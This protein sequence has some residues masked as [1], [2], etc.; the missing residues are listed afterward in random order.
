MTS[1]MTR[2]KDVLSSVG[3]TTAGYANR[4]GGRTSALA[5]RVGPKR[6]SVALGVLATAIGLRYL[7]RFLKARSAA[8]HREGDVM[9]GAH[10]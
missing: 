1:M 8:T 2:L 10:A 5:H 6:G 4:V 3:E 7:V 9:L